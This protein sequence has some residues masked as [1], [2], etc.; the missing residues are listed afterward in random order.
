MQ[1]QTLLTVQSLRPFVIHHKPLTPQQ[2]MQPLNAE[3]P[4][5]LC[6][7]PQTSAKVR[8]PVLWRRMPH[9]TTV[10]TVAQARRRE[11]AGQNHAS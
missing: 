2:D 4:P 9:S 5:F 8:I 7:F 10:D 1:G 6:Q 3:T 11:A